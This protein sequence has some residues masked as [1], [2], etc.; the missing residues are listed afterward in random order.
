MVEEGRFKKYIN[1]FL[2]QVFWGLLSYPFVTALI[3]L[4]VKI[5]KSILKESDSSGYFTV[6]NWIDYSVAFFEA[7]PYQLILGSLFIGIL[8]SSVTKLQKKSRLI[9][10]FGINFFSDHNTSR[11]IKNDWEVFVRIIQQ[12]NTQHLYILGATGRD[13]FQNNSSPLYEF[14]N[15]FQGDLKIMLLD[16]QTQMVNERAQAVSESV[17]EYRKQITGS[18]SYLKELNKSKNVMK[19]K[20]YS[21]LP[22]WK[23][24]MTERYLWLQ[25]YNPGEHVDNTPVFGIYK[26]NSGFHSLY[27]LFYYEFHKLWENS[28]EISFNLNS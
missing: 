14:V 17:T 16:P 8:I 20:T 7:H 21:D 25:C 19:V 11:Q 12:S 13:T 4:S 15:T 27:E 1:N 23:M 10:S 6:K 3:Y 5:A 2:Q 9:D 18:I 24:V 28:D 22:N 26:N